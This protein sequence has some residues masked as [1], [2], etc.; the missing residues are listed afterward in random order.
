M[1][2]SLSMPRPRGY[3]RPSPEIQIGMREF[4]ARY[5]EVVAYHHFGVSRTTIARCAAG[6]TLQGSTLRSIMEGL[7]TPV[8][9]REAL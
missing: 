9:E 3:L 5:G 4:L 1:T 6:L 7:A 8:A 2:N